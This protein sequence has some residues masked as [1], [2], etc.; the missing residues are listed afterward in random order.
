MASEDRF[1]DQHLE[2]Y[3]LGELPAEETERLDALSITDDALALRV[4]SIEHDLADAFVAGELDATRQARFQQAFAS[5]PQ[6]IAF[7][8]ALRAAIAQRATGAARRSSTQRV[9]HDRAAY[10]SWFDVRLPRWTWAVAACIALVAAL[11]VFQ[12]LRLRRAA[13]QQ[14]AQQSNQPAPVAAPPATRAAATHTDVAAPAAAAIPVVL[15]PPPLRSAASL[16]TATVPRAA[17]EVRFRLQLEAA[18]F[19]A[20]SAVLKAGPRVVWRSGKLAAASVNR[21]PEV[22][23]TVP[24]SVLRP[25]AMVLELSG[26]SAGAPQL[27][28]DY[29]FRIVLK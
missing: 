1:D 20:Y 11:L 9:R 27:V 26:I 3:L 21:I 10:R 8:E 16:P 15:L 17:A 19:P 29:A 7:A 12:N 22:A 2:R 28:G 25:Q 4:R 18:D 23:I 5:R 14:V 13:D 6:K 24:A